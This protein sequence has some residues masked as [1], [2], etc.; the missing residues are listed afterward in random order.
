MRKLLALLLSGGLLVGCANATTPEPSSTSSEPEQSSIDAEISDESEQTQAPTFVLSSLREDPE[1]CK[2]QEDSRIR[3][4]GDPIVEFASRAEIQGDYNGNATAFPFAPTVLPVSGELNVA[5]VL[6]DWEDLVG[7]EVDYAFY[8]LNAQL[9]SDFYWMVSEGKLKVNVEISKSWF[10]IPGSYADYAMTVEEE[11]QSYNKRP[12]KQALYDAIVAASDD[13]T[14]YSDVHVV[15]PAWPR[16]QTISEQGPHEFNFN[17]NAYMDTNEKRIYDIAGA[18]NWFL[19]NTQFSKGPWVYYAHEMGH[20]LGIPHQANEEQEFKDGTYERNES[21]W[22]TNPINGF[23]IMGNQDGAIKT[24]SAWLRW[25][26]GWLNDDQIICVEESSIVDEYFAL[27]PLNEMNGD[28][29]ALI[30][31]LSDTMVLV[32]ESRRWDKRFDRPIIHSRDG[33]VVYTV[34]ATKASAQGNQTILSPREITNWVEVGHWR[35]SEELD[36][37]FCEGDA[38]NVSNIRIENVSSQDGV[39][40]VRVSKTDSYVDP[41]PPL[42]GTLI[43]SVNQINDGCV[44]GP[45]ADYEYQKSLGLFD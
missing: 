37:N 25:L 10:R 34:D 11:G 42:A 4:P 43:G 12:K 21:W 8:T 29:E 38:L 32:V 6:V 2:I 7:K 24:L 39:D 18:G 20:M 13:E 36:G 26:P 44:W 41:A 35:H 14:D 22:A 31:K 33:L 3:N 5:M 15:L 28:N 9:L 19:N 16:G 17:W 27:N 30:I 1:L 40:Y 45:G 23:D